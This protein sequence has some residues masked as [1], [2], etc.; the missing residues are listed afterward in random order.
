[1]SRYTP[2]ACARAGIPYDPEWREVMPDKGYSKMQFWEA[3]YQNVLLAEEPVH[4]RKERGIYEHAN[5]RTLVPILNPDGTVTRLTPEYWRH[6]WRSMPDYDGPPMKP[7]SGVI[8]EELQSGRLRVDEWTIR[9]R[10][11]KRGFVG[12]NKADG[13]VDPR[14]WFGGR[15]IVDDLAEWQPPS[16]RYA[17]EQKAA[18]AVGLFKAPSE[19]GRGWCPK[20]AGVGE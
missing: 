17:R 12:K 16:A 20:L 10:R 2:E 8:F 9:K 19:G 13:F 11:P 14:S 6:E 15:G 3:A 4:A 1:M 18:R 7:P 5:A